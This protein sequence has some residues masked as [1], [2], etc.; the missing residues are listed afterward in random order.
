MQTVQL[1]FGLLFCTLS[2]RGSV[3]NFSGACCYPYTTNMHVCTGAQPGPEQWGDQDDSGIRA[4]PLCWHPGHWSCHLP[5]PGIKLS[6]IHISPGK[7]LEHYNNVMFLSQEGQTR[8]GSTSSS[9]KADIGLCIH[10]SLVSHFCPSPPLVPSPK[11]DVYINDV[12]NW[13]EC[14][15]FSLATVTV[16]FV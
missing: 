5:P 14:F 16:P 3:D 9:P 12:Q 13:I 10:C 1:T 2:E 8:I 6:Y 15:S 7:M 11:D 4:T